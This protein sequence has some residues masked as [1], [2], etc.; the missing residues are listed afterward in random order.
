MVQ[1]E[2]LKKYFDF[3]FD[4][5][6]NHPIAQGKDY[7]QA[8]EQG[9]RQ[10][11][12]IV[13]PYWCALMLL[14]DSHLP[15]DVRETGFKVLLLH[16]VLEDTTLPLPDFVEPRVVEL[17]K[18][19]TYETWEEER[20]AVPKKSI[21]VKLLKLVDKVATMYDEA[22][23]PDIKKRREWKQLTQTL[24]E[25]VSKVYPDSR[26]VTIAKAIIPTLDW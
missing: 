20:D 17:V 9:V 18:E 26:I 1:A 22:M 13:H 16:D 4:A 25:D 10:L 5:H 23:R 7:R 3:A 19:M 15:R 2:D 11:P 12:Y 8:D 21:D 14:N 24:L 6:Q